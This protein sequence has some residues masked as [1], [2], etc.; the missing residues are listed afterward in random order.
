VC[1]LFM[2]SRSSWPKEIENTEIC[3]RRGFVGVGRMAIGME[4]DFAAHQKVLNK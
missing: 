2:S 4:V 1:V 3:Y